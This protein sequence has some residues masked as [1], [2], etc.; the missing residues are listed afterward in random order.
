M[1]RSEADFNAKRRRRE[2]RADLEP[3][4]YGRALVGEEEA[5]GLGEVAVGGEFF[6]GGEPVLGEG[7]RVLVGQNYVA[8]GVDV[9]AGGG[10]GFAAP[11]HEDDEG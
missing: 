5:V 9:R 10:L 6:V 11:E 3:P 1:S 7:R 2:G 4:V 8:R